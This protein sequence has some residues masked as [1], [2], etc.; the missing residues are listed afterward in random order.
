[1][2]KRVPPL[3]AKRLERWRPDLHRTLELIDGAVAGLRVRLAPN[4][5]MSWSLS[6]RVSG[7][8]RRIALGKGLGLAEARRK[9]E[10]ARSAIANGADPAEARRALR[11][12]ARQL[13]KGSAR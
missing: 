4:G 6:A 2:P 8:R 9:A 7:I 1:M 3:N 11:L 12:V 10:E 5:E 13:C